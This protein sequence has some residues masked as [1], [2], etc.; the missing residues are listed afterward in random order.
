MIAGDAFHQVFA[1]DDEGRAIF[2]ADD[3]SMPGRMMM[4]PLD[5]M[6]HHGLHFMP[7]I[8]RSLDTFTP[9]A[10]ACAG[11]ENLALRSRE[12]RCVSMTAVVD[13]AFVA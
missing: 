3:V 2:H 10:R 9:D 4:S 8:T 1:H 11:C 13:V 6:F 12:R 5:T 7:A